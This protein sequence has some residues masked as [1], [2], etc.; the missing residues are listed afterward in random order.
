MTIAPALALPLALL[1]LGASPSK[2]GHPTVG[3]DVAAD[4]CESCHAS[5]TPAVVTEWEGGPHGLNLVKCFVCH[6]PAGK[7]L[8]RV[9][10]ATRC[11]GCHAAE[12]ASVTPKKGKARSCFACHAPHTLAAEGKEN[13]HLR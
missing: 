4:A 7:E 13:P 6:G 9:P 12:V 5:A 1:L 8:A 11:D 10:A 3:E 2:G